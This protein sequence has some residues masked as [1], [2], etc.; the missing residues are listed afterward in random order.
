LEHALV[1]D[2]WVPAIQQPTRV[3]DSPTCMVF[4]DRFLTISVQ[5]LKVD[6]LIMAIIS[7]ANIFVPLNYA[8]WPAFVS[9][10]PAVL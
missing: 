8:S 5:S 1:G 9:Q 4:L 6:A 7:I 3:R 2:E 10:E